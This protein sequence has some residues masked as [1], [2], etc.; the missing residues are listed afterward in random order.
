MTRS[1]IDIV[2]KNFIMKKIMTR[3]SIDIVNK[4]FI[5]KK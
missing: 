2:D 4:N 5:M 3:S 1:F